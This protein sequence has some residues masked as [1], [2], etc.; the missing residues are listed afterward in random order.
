MPAST[1]PFCIINFLNES[2]K[3]KVIEHTLNPLWDQSLVVDT[4]FHGDLNH[5]DIFA[6]EVNMEFFDKNDVVS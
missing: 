4:N 3:T 2:K 1:D 6:P 5:L